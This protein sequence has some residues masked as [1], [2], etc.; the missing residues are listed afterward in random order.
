VTDYVIVPR[1]SHLADPAAVIIGVTPNSLEVPVPAKSQVLPTVSNAEFVIGDEIVIDAGGPLEEMNRIAGFGS[2]I[3]QYPLKYDHGAGVLIN[4]ATPSAKPPA[5][6]P[7]LIT[8]S[9]APLDAAGFLATTNLCCPVEMEMFFNRLLESKGYD[10]CSKPHIQG[11]M[12]WFHC[13]PAM[14][15]QYV[16]EVIENGNPCK[17]WTPKGQACPVLSD[18]C[19]GHF[20]R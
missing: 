2:L 11:L 18:Q 5:T 4:A 9:T 7:V 14:D 1:A 17:Y 6:P 15:F 16:I 12:H 19:A 20:C 13:V 8:G 10:V 3:L